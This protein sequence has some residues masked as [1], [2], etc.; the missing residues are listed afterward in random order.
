[1]EIVIDL[2]KCVKLNELNQLETSEPIDI[3]IHALHLCD[4]KYVK[5]GLQEKFQDLLD[6]DIK[7]HSDMIRVY[8]EKIKIIFTQQSAEN[9][10][11]TYKAQID[12]MILKQSQKQLLKN[13]QAKNGA[14]SDL[15]KAMPV[16]QCLLGSI[17][18]L[19]EHSFANGNYKAMRNLYKKFNE[20]YSLANKQLTSTGDSPEKKK[21]AKRP[22]KKTKSNE[23]KNPN[24][25]SDEDEAGAIK[26]THADNTVFQ[27][28]STTR[29]GADPIL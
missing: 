10:V 5:L 2:S 4:D 9:L 3:L 11:Q 6:E 29:P 26:A 20:L 14:N 21:P 23:N 7:K 18:A 12:S 13:T 8:F 1:M 19:I 27:D 28:L 16:Y 24:E 25:K 15:S 22:S 17:E